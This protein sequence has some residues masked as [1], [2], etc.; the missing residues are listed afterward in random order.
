MKLHKCRRVCC[1]FAISTFFIHQIIKLLIKCGM[2][3]LAGEPLKPV[4]HRAGQS[5]E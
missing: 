3:K 2:G 4:P 5:S 1:G